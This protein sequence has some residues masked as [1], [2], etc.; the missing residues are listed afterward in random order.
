MVN[1]VPSRNIYAQLSY[2]SG[3]ELEEG[4][5]VQILSGDMKFDLETLDGQMA[6]TKTVGK[7]VIYS[8]RS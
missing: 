8:A 1:F 2:F 6:W 3:F 7:T 5:K 4:S